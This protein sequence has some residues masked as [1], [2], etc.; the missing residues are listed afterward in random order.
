MLIDGGPQPGK[1]DA[2]LAVLYLHMRTVR[3]ERRA[4]SIR[5]LNGRFHGPHSKFSPIY[6]AFRVSENT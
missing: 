4:I 2:T 3:Q 5:I 1:K 6:A